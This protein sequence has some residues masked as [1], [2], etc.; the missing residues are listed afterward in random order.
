MCTI[1]D[2]VYFGVTNEGLQMVVDHFSGVST[3]NYPVGTYVKVKYD[4]PGYQPIEDKFYLS[5]RGGYGRINGVDVANNKVYFCVVTIVGRAFCADFNFD[6]LVKVDMSYLTPETITAIDESEKLSVYQMMQRL[7]DKSKSTDEHP[8]YPTGSVVGYDDSKY[9]VVCFVSTD[10]N[11]VMVFGVGKMY[12]FA[13]IH[14]DNI[15]RVQKAETDRISLDMCQKISLLNSLATVFLLQ[16]REKKRRLRL[17]SLLVSNPVTV[18]RK[19]KIDVIQL[20]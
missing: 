13:V 16:E 2:N 11:Y 8:M 1:P 6:L 17:P 7:F 18:A 9:G 10:I 20:D 19:R 3:N 4:L 12:S 14:V 5:A 15:R